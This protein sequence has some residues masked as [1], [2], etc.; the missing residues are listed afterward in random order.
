MTMRRTARSLRFGLTSIGAV[1]TMGA[2]SALVFELGCSSLTPAPPPPQEVWVRV[3]SDPGRSLRDA[4]IT[5]RGQKIASSGDDG[6]AK[7]KLQGHEGEVFEVSVVCPVGYT[8]PTKSIAITLHRLDDPTRTPEFDAACPP[9]TRSIVVA[10]RAENGSNLPIVYLGREIARTDGAGA[11]TVLFN[12]KPDE[13]FDL[14]LKT[15]G[16]DRLRP[17]NPVATFRVKEQDDIFTFD[18]KFALEP[19]PV[20]RHWARPTGPIQIR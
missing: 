11:A 6:V 4:F 8:S 2:A 19:K 18:Q 14:S 9:A 3:H 10:V 7:L 5:Y 13:Q 12:M 15:A 1:A 17:Q 20:V 16:N